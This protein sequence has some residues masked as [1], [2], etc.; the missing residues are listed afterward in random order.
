MVG[1]FRAVYATFGWE[2]PKTEIE[3]KYEILKARHLVM[4]QIRDSHAGGK[5]IKLKKYIPPLPVT[6]ED[7]CTTD[8]ETY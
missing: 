8:D 5:K 2:Y 3:V 6:E 7:T 4:K 1:F